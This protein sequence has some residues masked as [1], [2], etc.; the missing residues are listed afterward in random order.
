[1]AFGIRLAFFFAFHRTQL[2]IPLLPYSKS[3]SVRCL[4]PATHQYDE[5]FTAQHTGIPTPLHPRHSIRPYSRYNISPVVC[6]ESNGRHSALLVPSICQSQPLYSSITDDA[7]PFQ[8][9]A[10][11][12]LHQY[13]FEREGHRCSS[14]LRNILWQTLAV[15]NFPGNV[16]DI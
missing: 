13:I 11:N 8:W 16:K 15:S 5:T 14:K 7:W 3:S 10:T 12:R 4:P 2:F 1:M 6:I 9:I